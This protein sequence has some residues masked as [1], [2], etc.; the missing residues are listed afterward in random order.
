MEKL[1]SELSKIRDVKRRRIILKKRGIKEP[2]LSSILDRVHFIVKGKEKYP[3]ATQ[4]KFDRD[5]LAQ[6]SSKTLAEYRT[7]KIRQQLGKV[8]L[9]LDVGSGI[10]GDTIFMAL[11]WKVISIDIDPKK[12]EML[13]HNIAVYNVV[14]NVEAIQGDIYELLKDPIFREKAGEVDF[15]F[16]APSRRK[17]WTRTTKFERYIPPLSLVDKLLEI[18]PNLCVEIAP[19]ADLSK[20]DYDCDIEIISNK[21]EVK[22]A[23]LWF[24]SLKL[25]PNEKSLMATKLPERITLV[26][27]ET[28][29]IEVVQPES[30]LYEPDPAFIKAQ[31]VN[32]LAVEYNL[33]LIHPQIAYLTGD[34]LVE[35]PLLKPYRIHAITELNYSEIN[36]ELSRLDIGR[37]DSKSRG[38]NI[39]HG[40]IRKQVKGSGRRIGVVIYTQINHKP[41]AIITTYI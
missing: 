1:V 27:R 3:R 16:F 39:D 34:K 2:E 8:N 4:M 12:M 22:E 5:G 36:N 18:C 29:S 38:V 41:K 13:H 37:V 6:A 40:D 10:G 25:N 33:K 11:R 23:V 35:T 15:I 7:W 14:D 17:G 9:A 24:G 30:F 32:D 26:K 20:I 28:H 21:G 31:L 19:A